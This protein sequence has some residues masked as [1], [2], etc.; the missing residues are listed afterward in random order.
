MNS[1]ASD[2]EYEG[3]GA[4]PSGMPPWGPSRGAPYGDVG[5][6]LPHQ[7]EQQSVPH[8]QS[9]H[10][11]QAQQQPGIGE[12]RQREDVAQYSQQ[13]E[14]VSSQGQQHAQQQQEVAA[15]HDAQGRTE[16]GRHLPPAP[17]RT[18]DGQAPPPPPPPSNTHALP[19]HRHP[20]H[21]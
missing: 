14:Q 12:W 1:N 2:S 21:P 6:Q 18:S 16:G 19:T 9:F 17:V 15:G 5:T 11:Q 7:Q 8:Q 10:R 3:P 20:N 4:T 13:P